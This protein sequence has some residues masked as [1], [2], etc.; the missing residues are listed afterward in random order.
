MLWHSGQ[1]SPWR[2]ARPSEPWSQWEAARLASESRQAMPWQS[3]WE[4][5]HSARR[6]GRGSAFPAGLQVSKYIAA[7]AL[8]LMVDPKTIQD[9]STEH[10]KYVAEFGYKETV[11]ADVKVPSFED[12][13]GIK[14][15]AVPGYSK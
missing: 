11:P 6:W 13:Y 5:A 4:A 9:A 12:L 8:N 7:S 3:Q 15:E 2:T 14:P 1:P 10:G